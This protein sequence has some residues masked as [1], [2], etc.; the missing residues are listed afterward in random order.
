MGLKT[1]TLNQFKYLTA[2]LTVTV[3]QTKLQKSDFKCQLKLFLTVCDVFKI[4]VNS[5]YCTQFV[6]V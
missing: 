5:W 4:K 6:I 2:R 1:F 3:E